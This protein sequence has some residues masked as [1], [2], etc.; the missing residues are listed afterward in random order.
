MKS[1]GSF[2]GRYGLQYADVEG[3]RELE[4]KYLTAS[5]YRRQGL[6]SEAVRGIL[7]AARREGVLRTVALI[8]SEN[9]PSRRV[10]EGVGFRFEKQITRD[11]TEVSLYSVQYRQR[12]EA[13]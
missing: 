8:L 6:A 7:D 9:V 13:G 3:V 5:E 11:G 12:A 1:T 10:A 4:V 2:V